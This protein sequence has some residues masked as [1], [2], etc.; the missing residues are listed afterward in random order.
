MNF[1]D[2]PPL[3]D[4]TTPDSLSFFGSYGA[5]WLIALIV[6]LALL[7]FYGL[8]IWKARRAQGQIKRLLLPFERAEKELRE[9]L[10]EQ[11]N[12]RKAS[13]ETSLIFRRVLQQETGDKALYETHEEFS[14]RP[15]AL[16]SLPLSLREPTR[17]YL[18]RLARLKYSPDE[19]AQ[20]AAPLIQEGIELITALANK[21][22]GD[23]EE[24]QK[25]ASA[26]NRH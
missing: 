9:L 21:I 14:L 20:D 2:I 18:Q 22:R 4:S 19:S 6:I 17:Q 15:D 7:V 13:L 16:N 11:L 25:T 10:G 26:H 24:N 23:A 5:V 1:D 3:K 8:R 12:V